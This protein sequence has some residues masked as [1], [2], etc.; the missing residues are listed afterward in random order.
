MLTRTLAA[1]AAIALTGATLAISTPV[2]AETIDD[3]VTVRFGDLDLSTRAGA[4]KLDRRLVSAAREVCGWVP[5]E[6]DLKADVIACR[7]R[8]VAKARSDL[9]IAM[10]GRAGGGRTVALRTN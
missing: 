8:A 6:M 9:Q 2:S 3:A 4:D 7:Q 1:L 10:A 5:R